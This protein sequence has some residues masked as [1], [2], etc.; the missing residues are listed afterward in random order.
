MLFGIL[1]ILKRNYR[2]NLSVI[3][4][5]AFKTNGADSYFHSFDKANY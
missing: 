2:Q 4:G 5:N 3:G 1:F